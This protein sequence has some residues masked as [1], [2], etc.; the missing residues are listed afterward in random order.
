MPEEEHGNMFPHL[1]MAARLER[2]EALDQSAGRTASRIFSGGAGRTNEGPAFGGRLGTREICLNK[3]V[4]PN[5]R[6]LC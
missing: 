2:N 3:V 6:A 5:E 4:L 1:S